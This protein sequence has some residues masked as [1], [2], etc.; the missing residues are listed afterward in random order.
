MHATSQAE[1]RTFQMTVKHNARNP[2][3]GPKG[4]RTSTSELWSTALPALGSGA[5]QA[6][7]F[8]PIDRALF[9]RVHHRR[10]LFHIDNWRNPFQGFGNAAS[11]RTLCGASYL[12]WQANMRDV[13]LWAVPGLQSHPVLLQLL[14]GTAAGSING[15]LLNHL[16]A[17][18]YRMWSDNR[19]TFSEVATQM[20]RVGGA[21][22]LIR[23]VGVSVMRDATF[24]IVYE[25][26][27]VPQYS[28]DR[29]HTTQ[30]LLNIIAGAAGS[31]V[32]SPINFTRNLI[33][34]AP[35]NSSPLPAR[36]L[37]SFL[38][39]EVQGRTLLEKFQ[40]IN[41]RLN[42]GWGSMRVGVGMACGQALFSLLK[43]N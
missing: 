23:G 4:A 22:V 8:N 30:F 19:G 20:W 32:S 34:G 28:K 10:P 41:A 33:Y 14:I 2:R 6:V 37:L 7:I 38:W 29:S 31:V 43:P 26:L 17:V 3:T 9:L 16:Q 25:T 18:K 12:F 5:I 13:A 40:H 35:F 1:F 39:M 42:V 24:G 21:R 27:R 15:C 36:Q 11:Y